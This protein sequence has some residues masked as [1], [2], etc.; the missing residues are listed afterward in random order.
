MKPSPPPTI[1][2]RV[3]TLEVA[4]AA[5]GLTSASALAKRMGKHPTTV[6]RTLA[7]EAQISGEFI[8]ALLNVFPLLR[9][10]QLFEVTTDAVPA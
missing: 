4:R 5:A 9:F 6:A 8:A 1:R 2:I 7:G 10:D 3:E